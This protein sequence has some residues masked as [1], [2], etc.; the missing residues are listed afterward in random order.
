VT[1]IGESRRIGLAD[2]SE[3]VLNTASEVSVAYTGNRRALRVIRGE[4]LFKVAKDDSRPFLVYAG[5][6]V[7]RATGTAFVIRRIDANIM[8]ITVT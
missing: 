6:V 2:G 7:V 5:Q 3:I 1:D 4:A 8:H